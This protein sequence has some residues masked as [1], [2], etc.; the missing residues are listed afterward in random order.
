M[1]C[2]CEWG[3][4]RLTPLPAVGSRQL[5][6]QAI[7]SRGDRRRGLREERDA[8]PR[9]CFTVRG[10]SNEPANEAPPKSINKCQINTHWQKNTPLCSRFL[11]LHVVGITTQSCRINLRDVTCIQ[12][13]KKSSK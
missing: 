10:A 1:K 11:S 3:V 7:G 8:C 2:V 4:G 13:V 5:G 6:R 9:Y 12:G